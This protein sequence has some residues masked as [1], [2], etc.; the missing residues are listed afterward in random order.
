MAK[1]VSSISNEL[2][3]QL[4]LKGNNECIMLRWEDFY[5]VCERERLADVVLNKIKSQLKK[6]EIHII[7][8][9]NV[10]LVRDFGWKLINL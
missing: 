3:D 5:K 4:R 2:K 9:N 6:E 7:Y 10:I 1:S 8:G